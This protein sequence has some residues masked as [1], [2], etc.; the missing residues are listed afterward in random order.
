MLPSKGSGGS[1]AVRVVPVAE[2]SQAQAEP[3]MR[4][5]GCYMLCCIF[6]GVSRTVR[7]TLVMSS[8]SHIRN[9]AGVSRP[10]RSVAVMGA[11]NVSIQVQKL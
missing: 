5:G 6:E 2:Q 9:G 4:I 11:F 3:L 10:A 7:C 1:A 8:R